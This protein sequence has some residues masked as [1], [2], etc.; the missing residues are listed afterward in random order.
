MTAARISGAQAIRARCL[1]ANTGTSSF[2]ARESDIMASGDNET[3]SVNLWTAG[4]GIYDEILAHPFSVGLTHGDLDRA[5]FRYFLL[6]DDHL[7]HSYVWTLSL[8]AARSP[9]LATAEMFTRHVTETAAAAR[10]LHSEIQ[11]DL[12]VSEDCAAAASTSPTTLAYINFLRA[13]TYG[14]TFAGALGAML[15]CYWMF[16]KVCNAL[17]AQSSPDP[18]Y[19]RFITT[20]GSED[21]FRFAN[22]L[23]TLIGRFESNF[24]THERKEM[25]DRFVTGARYEWMFWDAAYRR[26]EWL[27]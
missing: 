9:D 7:V 26:E 8:M 13:T 11:H 14:D 5:S 4:A 27:P 18:L 10:Q 21:S 24:T 17:A 2:S 25:Q 22:D 15:P 23:L 16:W 12:G 19:A 6:Q 20:Y 3:L 1:T